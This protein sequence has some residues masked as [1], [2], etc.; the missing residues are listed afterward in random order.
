VAEVVAPSAEPGPL[1]FVP[2]VE[3]GALRQKLPELA[4]PGRFALIHPTSRWPYK[5]WLPERW[6]EV[7]DGLVERLGL[8]VIFSCGPAERERETVGQIRAAARL[9]H[10]S[11]AGAL[12]LHE[13]GALLGQAR[14]FL[15]VDTVAMHLAAA[16]QTPTVALFGPSS[17]W[18]W[19]P[20]QCLH[21][22]VMGECTCKATRKFVCDKSRPYPCMERIDVE[23]VMSA[24]ERVLAGGPSEGRG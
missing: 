23:A 14:L 9:R 15:G 24:A 10:A 13:L 12:S 20:W 4:E 17:E 6:A 11:T 2:Q 5:Q 19:H 7:A 21:E 3:P 8:R 16:M 1:R 18:S 22:L